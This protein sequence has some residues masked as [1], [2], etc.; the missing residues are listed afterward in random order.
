MRNTDSESKWEHS[1]KEEFIFMESFLTKVWNEMSVSCLTSSISS[2][3]GKKWKIDA[4]ITKQY[5]FHDIVNVVHHN[6]CSF[7]R[8]NCF[9]MRS[10]IHFNVYYKYIFICRPGAKLCML[11]L[12]ASWR[13][14]SSGCSVKVSTCIR[15]SWWRSCRAKSCSLAAVLLDGVSI[16]CS[17]HLVSPHCLVEP[18]DFWPV[19]G[20]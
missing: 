12:N 16:R 18:I 14:I 1:F 13:V 10:W 5:F 11:L 2:E 9:Q 8:L 6:G 20:E 4:K 7:S 19:F 15:S 17:F 3:P